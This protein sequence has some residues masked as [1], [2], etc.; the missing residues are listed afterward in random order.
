MDGRPPPRSIGPVG[1]RAARAMRSGSGAE[2]PGRLRRVGRFLVRLGLPLLAVYLAL[3]YVT[4]A[5]RRAEVEGPTPP[6]RPLPA[7][8]GRLVTGVLSVHT[9][10]SHD[11]RGSRRQVAA[12]A[13]GAGL[14]F[15]VVGDHPRDDRRPGWRIWEPRFL[16]GV[17]VVGGQELRSP[18]AGKVLAMGVDTTYKR[19][20]GDYASFVRFLEREE[21]TAVVVHGRGRRGSER[22]VQP[23]A[24]GMD[25]WEILDV[26]ESARRRLAGPW[27]LYHALTLLVG[28]PLGLGDEALL[29]TM[30]EGFEVPAVAA[31]DS[32]RLDAR[33]TATAGLNVHPKVE[34]GSALLPPYGPFFRTLRTHVVLDGGLPPD[35]VEARAALAAG[36]R[37]GSVFVSM[38]EDEKARDFRFAALL[39][40]ENPK[41]GRR[42]VVTMGGAGS[43]A[44]RDAVLRAGFA[45]AG[46][47][48]DGSPRRLLYRVVRNGREVARIPGPELEWPVPGPGLYRVEVHRYAA[49]LG[50]VFFRLRPWIV[51]N[52]V[53]LRG[54]GGGETT[55]PTKPPRPHA[56]PG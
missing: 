44:Q 5:L 47:G 28:L 31:W 52:P 12:A 11:A 10:R 8:H 17:L 18:E 29:H 2:E 37:R 45:K 15:V 32:L 25:G 50:S 13:A 14:D 3:G 23:T 22:W 55:I 39:G 21:A 9:G 30:R 7:L 27:S 40:P 4:T 53:D 20:E 26:S 36:L 54:G 41:T 38:G 46:S 34:V 42:E 33:L 19:W 49:R 56:S 24:R 1:G 16:E 35:P 6:T 43:P 51:T 48:T